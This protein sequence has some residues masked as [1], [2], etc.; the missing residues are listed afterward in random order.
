MNDEIPTLTSFNTQMNQRAT[1]IRLVLGD[2]TG[3]TTT[4]R[5]DPL[6]LTEMSDAF[7]QLSIDAHAAGILQSRSIFDPDPKGLTQA[8]AFVAEAAP[9]EVE[10]VGLM[11]DLRLTSGMILRLAFSPGATEVMRALFLKPLEIPRQT[12]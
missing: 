4:L 8:A 11:A 3:R 6:Q 12:N 10:N 7:M 1:E 9:V 5:V 2:S